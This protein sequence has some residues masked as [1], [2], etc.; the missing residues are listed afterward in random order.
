M[1]GV[2]YVLLL[3]FLFASFKI[4]S[5]SMSPTLDTGDRVLVF[6]PILGPRLFN[7]F[8]TL[9]GEQA[10][11]YRAPGIRKVKRNDVVV[12]NFPHPGSWDKIEMHILKYYIKRCIGMPGDT[13]S[14]DNGYYKVKG[15]DTPLGNI[16]SQQAVSKRK[17]D[18]FEEGV[19][20]S[21]PYDSVIDWNIK[22]FG[23]FYIPKKGATLPMDRKNYVL[24]K[25]VIEWE[26]QKELSLTNDSII[27]LATEVIYSY[28]FQKNYYFMAGDRV[29]DS[30]DSRYWGLLPEEYI[31][32]KACLVW[33]SIDSYTGKF[34]WGRFMKRI[35]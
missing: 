15:V 31:V 12:L 2:G 24:Y 25:K 29:E 6:K 11:I 22:D 5:N 35:N 14:I 23:P 33:K 34:R 9:S 27:L 32:G 7:L 1:A 4:P 10:E 3:I 17:N 13:L 30:Q 18:T 16:A 20:R 28:Q 26:Q 19:F 21:F 8:T